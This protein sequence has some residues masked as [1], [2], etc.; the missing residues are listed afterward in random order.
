MRDESDGE[1]SDAPAAVDTRKCARSRSPQ[2][3]KQKQ[4]KFTVVS[5][6][7]HSFNPS[8][9]TAFEDQLLRAVISAGWSFNSIADP[10]V[11]KFFHDWIP[12]AKVPDR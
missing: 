5:A 6:K 9:Q 3:V 8:K 1:D 7:A 11:Q 2:R 4:K 10:E 12:G